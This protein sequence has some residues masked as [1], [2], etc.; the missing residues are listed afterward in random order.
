MS[1]EL[2]WN[3]QEIV[4]YLLNVG[5]T[6]SNESDSLKEGDSFTRK[7]TVRSNQTIVINGQQQHV[8]PKEINV[9]IT[10]V[11]TG[12][13]DDDLIYGFAIGPD[14]YGDI[15]YVQELWEIKDILNQLG[16]S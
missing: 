1:E 8:P 13:I 15:L 10:Y 2:I 9:T 6:R 4:D 12:N 7:V 5:F 11:G 14:K 3:P 16:I